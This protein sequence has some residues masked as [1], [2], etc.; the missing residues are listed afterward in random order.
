MTILRMISPA[1]IVAVVIQLGCQAFKVIF[2]SARRR[3]FQWRFFFSAG[4]MPSSHSAFV[5]ALAVSV[6]LGS[7]FATDLFALAFVFAA[8]VIYD[9]IRLRG[10]VQKQSEALARLVELL[11]EDDRPPVP[12]WVGHSLAEIAVG[13]LVGGGVAYLA[14]LLFVR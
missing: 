13:V 5:T 7:G 11:P 8:I 9:A 1:L 2:Y 12:M 4:G 14:F 3:S 6:G 10:A